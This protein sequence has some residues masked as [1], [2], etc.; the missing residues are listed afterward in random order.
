MVSMP[1]DVGKWYGNALLANRSR[2]G[3]AVVIE[4]Y[5]PRIHLQ[6]H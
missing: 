4:D 2:C 3:L 5:I 1:T 6:K